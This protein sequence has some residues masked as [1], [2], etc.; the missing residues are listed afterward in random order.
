[1]RPVTSAWISLMGMDLLVSSTGQPQTWLSPGSTITTDRTIAAVN[2]N[3]ITLDAPL[4]DSFDATVL[5]PA[6]GS[7]IHYAFPG[8]IS[9]VGV[10][11]LRVIAPPLNVDIAQPQFTGLSISAVLNGWAVDLGFQ[12]TQNTVD[13]GGNVKQ[14]T[15][16]S[17]NVTHTIAHTGDRMAD[18]G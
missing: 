14:V 11:H 10:E 3:Q 1:R 8:R 2:G 13:I 17:I 18:F 6:E 15:L 12:D 4:T 9:Q 16:D 5:N 7:I